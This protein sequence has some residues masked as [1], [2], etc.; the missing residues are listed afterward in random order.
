MRAC[1]PLPPQ[2]LAVQCDVVQLIDWVG[3]SNLRNGQRVGFIPGQQSAQVA[4]GDICHLPVG[5]IRVVQLPKHGAR[6]PGRES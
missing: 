4:R 5:D 3:E 6:I 2:R 1:E